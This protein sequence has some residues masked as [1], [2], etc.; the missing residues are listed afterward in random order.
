MCGLL[1][2]VC[3]CVFDVQ[4]GWLVFVAITAMVTGGLK[5]GWVGENRAS[6]L[7]GKAQFQKKENEEKW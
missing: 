6:K 4:E 1:D 5:G 3:D 2:T 7:G